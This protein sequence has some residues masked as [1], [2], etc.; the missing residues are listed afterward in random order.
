MPDDGQFLPFS[1]A[2]VPEPR[3]YIQ[4]RME[5]LQIAWAHAVAEPGPTGSPML[6]LEFTSGDRA[7]FMAG[8]DKN[9]RFT[10]RVVIAWMPAPM[11]QTQRMKRYFSSGRDGQRGQKAPAPG[12]AYADAYHRDEPAGH[13]VV[14]YLE[15]AVVRSLRHLPEAA[16]DGGERLELELSGGMKLMVAASPTAPAPF[17]ADLCYELLRPGSLWVP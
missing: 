8:K 15:G 4:E 5:G 1:G 12:D 17:A 10:A 14:K 6:G 2:E 16:D 7:L 9:S 3:A 13:K 11:I